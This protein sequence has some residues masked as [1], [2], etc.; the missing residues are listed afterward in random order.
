MPHLEMTC[1]SEIPCTK[2]GKDP[3]KIIAAGTTSL[4]ASQLFLLQIV[5]LAIAFLLMHVERSVCYH[6]PILNTNIH[7]TTKA[8]N[9]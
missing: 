2:A 4:L 3:V 7:K 6:P 1:G 8:Y 5:I 9:Y